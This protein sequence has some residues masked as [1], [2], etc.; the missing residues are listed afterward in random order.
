MDR[1]KTQDAIS[2]NANLDNTDIEFIWTNRH[3]RV[4]SRD[5]RPMTQVNQEG[6][7]LDK[8]GI[9]PKFY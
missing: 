6:G 3:G 9:T 2:L 8:L 4:S 5:Y 7:G 1:N